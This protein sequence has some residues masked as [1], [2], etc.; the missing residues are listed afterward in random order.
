MPTGCLSFPR[1][2][3]WTRPSNPWPQPES[4]CGMHVTAESLDHQ[5]TLDAGGFP[6]QSSIQV[7][8]TWAFG[9]LT[10]AATYYQTISSTG[11]T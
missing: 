7:V 10:T 4:R 11:G 6:V 8:R 2:P 3:T 1:Q 5:L 9:D